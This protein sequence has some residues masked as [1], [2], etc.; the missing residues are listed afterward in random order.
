[1]KARLLMPF[2]LAPVIGVIL[3]IQL[4]RQS[5][6]Q[7]QDLARP[8]SS[9]A[10][11]GQPADRTT[12][13][14]SAWQS[15]FE[16]SFADVMS[17][18]RS[19]GSGP[20]SPELQAAFEAALQLPEGDARSQALQRAF[21][22][23]LL[24]APTQAMAYIS[25]I[26]DEDRRAVTAAAL[27]DLAQ[28]LPHSF[29]QYS[30]SLGQDGNGLAAVIN[31]I[32]DQHP[33]QA[34]EWLRQHAELDTDGAL[35]AAALPGLIRADV[36]LAARTVADM[37]ERAPLALVQ[38]VAAAYARHDPAQAY[39][40]AS[41]MVSTQPDAVPSRLLDEVSSSL[42]ASDQDAA[43]QFMSRTADAGVRKSLMSEIAI[44]KGQDD[45]TAAWNWLNQYSSD[46]GYQE[47]AQNLLYRWSYTK[48]Q[49]V[50]QILPAIGNP[51]LQSNAAAYL[52]Q[53]WQQKDPSSYQGWVASLPP[54][55]LRASALAAR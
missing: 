38:Q 41:Q 24:E 36:A 44:R 43:T 33:A 27:A 4:F 7:R 31:A 34:L 10:P 6:P 14:G 54:G 45:L 46:P 47:A 15:P 48:P 49:E 18:M 12:G 17:V 42:V 25:R 55:Q 16:S 13:T 35:T 53:F 11:E 2:L 8:P 23:W 19:S 29:A 9:A 39:A 3:G 5:E 50:A 32:A 52:T 26:P 20:A 1:M 51:T 22:R 28:R 30:A 21:S 40:W 37:Q